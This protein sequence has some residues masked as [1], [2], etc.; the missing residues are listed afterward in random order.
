[1]ILIG[2]LIVTVVILSWAAWAL[3]RG[4]RALSDSEPK[5]WRRHT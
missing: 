5:L 4:G 1:M 3:L 2:V